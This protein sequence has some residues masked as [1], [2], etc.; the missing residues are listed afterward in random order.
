VKIRKVAVILAAIFCGLFALVWGAWL[1]AVPSGLITGK[2]SEALQES[3]VRV[4][5]DN[6]R[7][8]LFYNIKADGLRVSSAAGGDDIVYLEDLRAG[9]NVPSVFRLSPCLDF[10]ALLSGGDITGRAGSDGSLIINASGVDIA[11]L[12]IESFITGLKSGGEASFYLDTVDGEGEAKLHVNGMSFLPYSYMGFTLPLD[13]LK[14][15]RAMLMMSSGI[16][17]VKSA[18]IEGDGI[19]SRAKGTIGG[20][21]I[22]I[23]IE[24]MPSEFFESS[25]PYFGMLQRFRVTK[26]LYEIPVRRP[27]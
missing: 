26:G 8:G 16:V 2:L 21:N 24:L 4:E 10:S 3:K 1:I 20:G 18:V 5:F 22:D 19:Y 27:Y 11:G 14:N 12:G 13:V 17:T 25:Q 6:F 7:K 23:L 15:A 9:L